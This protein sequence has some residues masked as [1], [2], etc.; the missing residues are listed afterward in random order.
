M[1]TSKMVTS[2]IPLIVYHGSARCVTAHFI[3]VADSLKQADETNNI[4]LYLEWEL[5]IHI[6]SFGRKSIIIIGY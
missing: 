6:V 2:S 4:V 3:R 1:D 5:S